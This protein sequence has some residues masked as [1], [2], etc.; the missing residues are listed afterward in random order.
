MRYLTVVAQAM[1]IDQVEDFPKGFPKVSCF[2]DSDDAFMVY[3]RFGTVFARLLLSKQ[4]EI[5][6]LE[7]RLLGMDRTDEHNGDSEYLMS[8]AKDSARDPSKIPTSWRNVTRT[9]LMSRLERLAL[10]YCPFLIL[11][12]KSFSA[13]LIQQNFFSELVK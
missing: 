1:L 7:A 8:V 9:Q 3:R 6:R 13:N 11:L 2:V 5:R 10:E 12:F 4:D